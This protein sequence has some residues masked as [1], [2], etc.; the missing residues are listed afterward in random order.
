[1][2]KTIASINKK[3]DKGTVKVVRADEMTKIVQAL[4]PEKAAEEVDVVT[5]GTFGAMCSSGVW[6]NFGHSEPPIRMA[7]VWLNDV[8]AYTGVAAVDAYLGATQPSRGQGIQYGGSHVI[9][10]LLKG[11][12]VVL[13]AVSYGT[14]CYPRK[15]IIT[16]VT[17]KELNFALMS[18]PRNG[19]QR[20]NAAANS[21]GKTLYTY[22]G[23]LLP[24]FGNVTFSGA[25]ELSPLMND[26]HYRTLGLGSRIFIGGAQGYIT[27]SGTQHS[28]QSLFGTLMVQ[29][30]LKKMSAEFIR[31]ATFK[32]YGCSLYI[33]LGV[34]IP[35]LNPEIARFTGIS[36][37]EIFTNILDYGVPSR[38]RPV[39]KKVS[40]TELKSG[41][42][43]MDGRR[44][45]ASPLSS[46]LMA[47]KIAG[48]LKKWIEKG[49]F[50]LSAPVERLSTEATV[51]PLE[52]KP[53]PFG[54]APEKT[55]PV[56]DNG[57]LAWDAARCIHCGLCLSLCPNRVFSR[58]KDWRLRAENRACNACGICADAC[59]LNAIHVA[60]RKK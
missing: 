53:I 39:L 50:K 56:G 45:P 25:G 20:Y 43:D 21:S 40:Y 3:I 59:P 57:C 16:S 8:E 10:D 52:V 51:N 58:S 27:G 32:G 13:R 31:A 26:P 14:D 11:K 9:E 49:E 47:R 54:Q 23:K 24:R 7:R 1:M 12:P 6:M 19:Y 28:P 5:T 18:N 30:D 29:G 46:Y 4:G 41:S 44:V 37:R 42:I 55:P 35:V 22:M 15:K 2:S 34:P 33:G 17:L 36:D 48:I 60:Q 38:N